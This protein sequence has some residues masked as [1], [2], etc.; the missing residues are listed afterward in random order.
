MC[1]RRS[2]NMYYAAL[3]I[4]AL[5][6]LTG[7]TSRFSPP[8]DTATPTA[9]RL[10]T[11]VATAAASVNAPPSPTVTRAATG[12]PAPRATSVPAAAASPAVALVLVAVGEPRALP[13]KLLGASSEPMIEHLLDDPHKAEA[14]KGTRPAI[15]RFPGG[16]QANY[17]N[18]RSGLPVFDPRSNSSAYYKFWAD[19]APRIARAFPAGISQEQY[20]SFAAY[21]G[22]DV[23]LVPNLETSTVDEQA[24]WF[25]RLAANNA[26]PTDI[27]LGNE[28]WIAMAGDP[29]VMRTWPD[30]KTSQAVMQRYAQALRPI[31]GPRA[32]FAAQ[33]A[34]AGFTVVPTD[35]RPFSRRLLQWDQDLKPAP[36]F[37]AVTVHL[38]PQLDDIAAA[39]GSLAP[40]VVFPLLMARSDAG[41]DRALDDITRR[42]PGKEIWVTEWNPRGGGTDD[43]SNYVTPSMKAHLVARTTLAML[44]HPSMTKALY[45]TL[46]MP[47]GSPFQ[48]YLPLN[49]KFVPLAETAVLGWFNDAA[50]G[51]STF[52]RVIDS[53]DGPLSGLGPFDESY[54]PIEGGLFRSGK[55]TVLIV[56][57]ATAQ[58]RSFDPLQ[59]GTSRPARAEVLAASALADPARLPAAV[60]GADVSRTLVLPPFS[61]AR[62]IWE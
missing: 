21:L 22:A 8:P 17:Y 53:T 49:D 25:R 62:L 5:V 60:T 18:W 32:K 10:P 55:R 26:L 37:D 35:T 39:A 43:R 41:V 15:V 11:L 14:I 57:N 19:A 24:A 42:V 54:R 59:L 3:A 40:D 51:G 36:W 27:E 2:P 9:A 46:N 47:D 56:Q 31:V 52:Q 23:L 13:N 7:C 4:A 28:F 58:A 12:T 61:L 33:A 6:L 48:A 20:E 34:A 50:N 29:N 38:Y 45:F 16:S 1:R 44:R 30:L